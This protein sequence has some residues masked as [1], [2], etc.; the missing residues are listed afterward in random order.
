MAGRLKAMIGI[1]VS[2]LLR[3]G[4]ALMASDG[5]YLESAHPDSEGVL[6]LP[7]V[8]LDSQLTA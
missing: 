6:S 1:R 3:L 7:D 5:L 8:D 4:Q 2:C